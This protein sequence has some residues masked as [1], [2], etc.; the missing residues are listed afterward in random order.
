MKK[1][2]CLSAAASLIAALAI[3]VGAAGEE[4]LVLSAPEGSYAVGETVTVTISVEDIGEFNTFMFYDP[5]YDEEYLE[6]VGG[7]WLLDGGTMSDYYTGD[8]NGSSEKGRSGVYY[9]EDTTV[10]GNADIVTME[11]EVL[12]ENESP[13]SI[14]CSV[15]AKNDDTVVLNSSV[16][17]EVTLGE[18]EIK[19]PVNVV[20]AN[21]LLGNDLTMNFFIPKSSLD[22]TGYYA[23][24]TKYYADGSAPVERTFQFNEWENYNSSYYRVNFSGIAAKEMSDELNV[25]IYHSNG[26]P[27]GTLWIDSIAGYAQRG[28]NGWNNEQKTWAVDMLNYG[29]AAQTIFKYNT[30][31]LANAGLTEEQQAYATKEISLNNTLVK[32]NNYFASTLVME[33]NLCLTVYF[34][35]LTTDMYAVVSFTDHY[36]NPQEFTVNG[37]DFRYNSGYLG[38]AIE[39]MVAADARCPITVTIY[40]AD[41]S[42]YGT[43]TDSIESYSARITKDPEQYQAVMKFADSCYNILH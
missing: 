15:I 19:N 14:G 17:T 9:A 12:K 41:G 23:V 26:T 21:M 37:E 36:N 1:I 35:N 38:V 43:A 16:E 11:F 10:S 42:V 13:L 8:M 31:N 33:S 18:E 27:A 2:I 29:A 5:V 22:G 20:G 7:D 34:K 40:N 30:D 4:K 6:W 25:Q 28:Y 3:G 24:V 32:G 39:T